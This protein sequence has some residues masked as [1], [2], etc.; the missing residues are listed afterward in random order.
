[1]FPTVNVTG[2]KRDTGSDVIDYTISGGDIYSIF[3]Q[4][5]LIVFGKNDFN[6]K[7]FIFLLV[8]EQN[9]YRVK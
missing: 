5:R 2:G 9:I 7:R 1:M 8:G 3:T 6:G 4:L